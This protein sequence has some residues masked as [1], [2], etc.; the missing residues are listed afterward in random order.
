M[1]DTAVPACGALSYIQAMTNA[2]VDAPDWFTAAL[3]ADVETGSVEVGGAEI[4]YRAWGPAGS[5]GVVLVHGGGAHSHW[6]DHIGPLLVDG[7]RVVAVDLSGHGDSDHRDHYQLE[8]WSLEALTVAEA[9]GIAGAPT[10]VGHSMGG[11]VSFVAAHL[12]GEKL[13]GVQIIDS[14]IWSRS[15]EEDQARAKAAFGPKKVYPTQADGLAH[16]RLVP[17][18][19]HTLPY[20]V[21]HVAATSMLAVDGGWSWKFDP[22]MIKR[23]GSAHL[24]GGAPECRLAFFRSECGILTEETYL[25]MRGRFGQSSLF[26]TLPTAGHHPMIDQPLVLVTAIRA[27][28]DAWGR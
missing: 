7:R 14:P 20:V 12:F 10:L 3:A 18:Q 28:L 25:E 6:W 22:A 9:G 4:H 11:M 23:E 24:G 1:L 13:E 21:A 8:Q 17:G 16:F 27:T 5:P 2:P 19:E 15:T 26:T